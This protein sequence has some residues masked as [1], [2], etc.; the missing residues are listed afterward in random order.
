ML[1]IEGRIKKSNHG[2]TDFQ[3]TDDENFDEIFLINIEINRKPDY[4]LLLHFVKN[5]NIY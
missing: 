3:I 4:Y 1:K 2:N 5:I